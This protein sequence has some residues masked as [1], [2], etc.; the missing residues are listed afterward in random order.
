MS[1]A[2]GKSTK[3]IRDA[4]DRYRVTSGKRFDLHAHATDDLPHGMPN[5][6]EAKELLEHGIERMS[7]LQELLF[8]NKTWSLLVVFQAMDAAGKD[9]TIKHV[10]SGVNPQG[11]RVTPFQ[12]PGPL[13]LEHDFLWRI[14]RE[15]PRRGSI[16]IFN[17]SHY[18]DVLVARVH[19]NLVQASGLPC[20]LATSDDL[21]RER[22]ADIAAYEAYLGR[23]GTRVVKFFLNVG[24]DEQKKRFLSRLETPDKIWK[25]SAADLRERRLWDK[26]QKAYAAAI[27]GT[28]TAAAPW[29]VI[30]ADRKWY[31]RLMVGEAIIQALESLDLKSPRVPDDARR[32]LDAARDELEGENA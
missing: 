4:L 1:E 3:R 2:P 17:R 23:Q 7:A 10:M 21:W 24:R 25:F 13:E 14:N 5:K 31:M 16:G 22:I 8:A 26:Y 12:A 29:Y 9:S 28:A 11:V 19:K 15:L 30:P 32:E 20:G 18:E 27:A 6:G